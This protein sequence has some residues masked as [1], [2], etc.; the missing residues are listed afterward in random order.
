MPT[1]I[2]RDGYTYCQRTTNNAEQRFNARDT[3][4]LPAEVG[5]SHHAL[6]RIE[7]QPVLDDVTEK[8]VKA[9]KAKK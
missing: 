8:P 4:D 6:Q 7:Q 1:Y 2:V 9:T 5:D 3:V